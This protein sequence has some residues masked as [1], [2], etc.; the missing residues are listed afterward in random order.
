MLLTV[1][2]ADSERVRSRESSETANTVRA[3][4]A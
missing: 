4:S 1:C 2:L 3:P